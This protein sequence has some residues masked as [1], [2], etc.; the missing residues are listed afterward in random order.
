VMALDPLTGG[1]PL[2]ETD[3]GYLFGIR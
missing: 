2:P 1:P 3:G